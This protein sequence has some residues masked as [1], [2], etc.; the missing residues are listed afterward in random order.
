MLNLLA[1][2]CLQDKFPAEKFDKLMTAIKPCAGEFSW[3]DE[4]SWLTSVQQARE[5]AAAEGKPILIWCS[6]DGQPCGAT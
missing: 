3:H 5:K 6:A 1:A 4:I 2:L